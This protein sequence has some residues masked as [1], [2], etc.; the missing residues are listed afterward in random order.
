MQKM[1]S[2]FLI[3][4]AIFNKRALFFNKKASFCMDNAFTYWQMPATYPLEN[5]MVYKPITKLPYRII[6]G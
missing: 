6:L 5:I 2:L 1:A 4:E 3:N